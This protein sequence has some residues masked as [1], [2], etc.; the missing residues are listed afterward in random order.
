MLPRVLDLLS[1]GSEAAAAHAPQ[2]EQAIHLGLLNRRCLIA[3]F[4]NMMLLCPATTGEQVDQLVGAF[5]AV[6]GA[7][8]G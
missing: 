1:L 8:A 2:I 4:H 5:G 3:P 6:V 7:I